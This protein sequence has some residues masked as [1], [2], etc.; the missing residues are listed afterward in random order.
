VSVA[1]LGL[2]IAIIGDADRTEALLAWIVRLTGVLAI[3]SLWPL[4]YSVQQALARP[5]NAT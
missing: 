5:R 4:S 1:L 2:A 3:W